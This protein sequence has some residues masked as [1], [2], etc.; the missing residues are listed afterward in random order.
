MPIE[1]VKQGRGFSIYSQ[2]SFLIEVRS[3]GGYSGS[4]VILD[5]PW[6][7]ERA[8]RSALRIERNATFVLG[9]DWS[10]LND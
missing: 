2:E 5:L 1:P 9:I 3:V 6:W 4:A 10:H 8:G 7:S